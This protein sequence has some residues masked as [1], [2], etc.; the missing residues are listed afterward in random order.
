MSAATKPESLVETGKPSEAARRQVRWPATG[1]L[2]TALLSPF[3]PGMLVAA[4]RLKIGL[5]M[6]LP[7]LIVLA[8]TCL[9]AFGA[10]RMRRLESRASALTAATAGCFLSFFN[11]FCLPFAVWSLA[12]LMRKE[13]REAFNARSSGRESAQT[14]SPAAPESQSRLTLAAAKSIGFAAAVTFFYAGVILSILVV[15]VLPFRFSRDSAYLLGVGIVLVLAPFV[16]AATVSALRRAHESNDPN[17]MNRL[18]IWFRATSVVAWLL[19]LPVIGFAMFFLFAMTQERGGWNPALS[20]ALLVPLAWLGAILLP[21]GFWRLTGGIT[22]WLG[23]TVLGLLILGGLV[24]TAWGAIES[25]QKAARLELKAQAEVA[26]AKR[27]G[28]EIAAQKTQPKFGPVVERVLIDPDVTRENE[29]LNLLSGELSSAEQGVPGDGGQ[30]LIRLLNSEGDVFADFDNF[31][32]GRWALITHGLKLSDLTP[33]QWETAT[34]AALG[35]ALTAP[36]AVQHVAPPEL[37]GATLYVFPNEILP[38]TFA[39]ETRRGD[40]GILQITGFT[41]NPRGVRIRYKLAQNG[42]DQ[43]RDVSGPTPQVFFGPETN[44]LQAALQLKPGRAG[45]ALGEPIE[46]LFHIRN[47]SPKNIFVSGGSWRQEDA[48]HI[49]IQDAQGRTIP[50]QHIWYSGITPVQRSVLAPGEHAIFR[51]SGLEFLADDADKKK[52]VHPVGNYVTVKPGRYT[53]SYRLRFPDL[54]EGNAPTPYDWQGDLDTAPVTVEIKPA[55]AA[56]ERRFGPVFERT[57]RDPGESRTNCFIDF[58]SGALIVPPPDLQMTNHAAVWEWVKAQDVD[59]IANTSDDSIRGLL[60]YDLVVVRLTDED[61]ERPMD[62]KLGGEISKQ[63]WS[64]SRFGGL[65]PRSRAVLTVNTLATNPKP[66][67]TYGFRT[68]KGTLGLLQFVDYNDSPRGW[69]KIRYKLVQNSGG[70]K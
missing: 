6:L 35:L 60:G 11:L 65:P 9:T 33:P 54:V 57:L 38:L 18:G 50:V 17:R 46:V 70:E 5:W 31:V 19:A 62:G 7:F 63:Q 58:E 37:P 56:T 41:E 48:R 61:W 36:S 1:L 28:E 24:L 53:V 34:P 2:V 25:E 21:F 42:N 44:G 66:S 12:V 59:A 13:V 43:K 30:R 52:V 40:R 51:S 20:E 69:V 22:R 29:T 55:L 64:N 15:G 47:V 26:V 10:L 32:S 23:M 8:T 68:R 39:F 67:K 49:T 27:S 3:L 16:G 14:E 4:G 45:Y